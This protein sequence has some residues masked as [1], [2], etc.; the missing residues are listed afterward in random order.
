MVAKKFL[1]QTAE[2]TQNSG[3]LPSCC[4]EKLKSTFKYFNIDRYTKYIT[5]GSLHKILEGHQDYWLKE[6][7]DL[8]I[9]DEAH[10]LKLHFRSIPKFT[11]NL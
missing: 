1:L 9:V 10:K 4:G 3:R 8:I 5:N 6:E 11:T 2:T 7:Y